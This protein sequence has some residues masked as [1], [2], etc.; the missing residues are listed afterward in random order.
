MKGRLNAYDF[1]LVLGMTLA[2][3]ICMILVTSPK[4]EFLAFWE[5]EG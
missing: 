4:N 1:P 2:D 3:T 5:E